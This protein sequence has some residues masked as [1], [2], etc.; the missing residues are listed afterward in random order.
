MHGFVAPLIALTSRGIRRGMQEYLRDADGQACCSC[1]KCFALVPLAYVTDRGRQCCMCQHQHQASS[2]AV[3]GAPADAAAGVLEKVMLPPPGSAFWIEAQ[4]PHGTVAPWLPE[5]YRNIGGARVLDENSC[6]VAGCDGRLVKPSQRQARACEVHV[7]GV[8]YAVWP[9]EHEAMCYC[10]G[11]GSWKAAGS[12]PR[13]EA[14]GKRRSRCRKCFARDAAPKAA[15]PEAGVVIDEVHRR[16]RNR[17]ALIKHTG[18][19]HDD[20]LLWMGCGGKSHV[21]DDGGASAGE[22][23]VVED[24]AVAPS[25]RTGWPRCRVVGCD[26]DTAAVKQFLCEPHRGLVVHEEVAAGECAHQRHCFGCRVMRNAYAFNARGGCDHAKCTLVKARSGAGA[27]KHLVNGVYPGVAWPAHMGAP[28]LGACRDVARVMGVPL[29]HHQAEG[30]SVCGHQVLDEERCTGTCA[31]GERVCPPHRGKVGVCTATAAMVWTCPRCCCEKPLEARGAGVCRACYAG[32]AARASDG[33]AHQ[34]SDDGDCVVVDT[35]DGDG[36]AAS[37]VAGPSAAVA[38]NH[39]AFGD[40]DTDPEAAGVNA[41]PAGNADVESNAVAV[42]PAAPR[43]DVIS[44]GDS[45][46][47]E[48]AGEGTGVAEPVTDMRFRIRGTQPAEL[49][50]HQPCSG[51]QCNASGCVKTLSIGD[52]HGGRCFVCMVTATRFA[53]PVDLIPLLVEPG[54]L[55]GG[56][57]AS[58]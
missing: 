21:C 45:D 25:G 12:W 28:T 34:H 5:G 1:C 47:D 43:V 53:S 52:G 51:Q 30:S 39:I 22:S 27:R 16:G 13:Y 20:G 56:Q 31:P 29:L 2:G 7:G 10:H 9:T 40:S 24:A 8:V 36:E 35:G 57:G 46:T 3:G 19:R 32:T 48:E 6:R 15:P 54:T 50:A 44:F 42:A 33:V 38:A 14:T 55:R 11:C 26:L 37:P 49:P 17:G 23:T 58:V 41:C 18:S 4:L